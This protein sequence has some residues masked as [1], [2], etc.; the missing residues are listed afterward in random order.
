MKKILSFL[1]AALM[2]L[3]MAACSKPDTEEEL[4]TIYVLTKEKEYRPDMAGK[5]ILYSQ[6]LYTYDDGANLLSA[7]QD[8]GDT[9]KIW[10]EDYMV[11]EYAYCHINGTIDAT[12]EYQYDDHGTLINYIHTD[13]D[14]PIKEGIKEDYTKYGITYTYNK[15][16]K[17]ESMTQHS[18]S[19]SGEASDETW[20]TFY[21]Y[22]QNGN[23]IRVES[24]QWNSDELVLVN[25]FSYDDQNRLTQAFYYS[26]EHAQLFEYSYDDAGRLKTLDYSITSYNKG[27]DEQDDTYRLQQNTQFTYD[28]QGNRISKNTYDS[29]GTLI[30]PTICEYDSGKLTS[31]STY[32]YQMLQKKYTFT[33]SAENADEAGYEVSCNHTSLVY[34]EN[35]NLIRKALSEVSGYTYEYAAMRVTKEQAEQYRRTQYLRNQQ[36]A[37]GSTASFDYSIMKI[38]FALIP[39]PT[40]IFNNGMLNDI[41]Q[42]H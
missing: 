29:D 28:D 37:D 40:T 41:M 42:R 5:R 18:I 23:L 17:I 9:V 39:Y 34:D 4:V 31:V 38:H 21:R 36:E 25:K 30:S 7:Q 1:L 13:S 14:Y 15:A 35:G 8:K 32:V 11:Y 2:L 3:S 10:N 33:Y 20:T 12:W 27:L 16:G 26:I 19:M 6:T 24:E 22:D